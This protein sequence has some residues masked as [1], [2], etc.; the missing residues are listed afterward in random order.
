MISTISAAPAVSACAEVGTAPRETGLRAGHEE[1]MPNVL[2]REDVM[3]HNTIPLGADS[4]PLRAAGD[5]QITF[6]A[7]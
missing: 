7:N 1:I 6:R 5:G 3:G 4:L 2:D